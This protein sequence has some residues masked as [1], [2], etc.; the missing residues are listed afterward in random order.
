M[1]SQLSERF[2]SCRETSVNSSVPETISRLFGRTGFSSTRKNDLLSEG[3]C[4]DSYGVYLVFW[5]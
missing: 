3:S 5:V 1:Q 2:S 4:E